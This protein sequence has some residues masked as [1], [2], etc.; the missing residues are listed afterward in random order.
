MS[1]VPNRYL[2]GCLVATAMIVATHAETA[3]AY[4]SVL[5][6]KRGA[7][8]GSFVGARPGETGNDP[9]RR[10]ERAIGRRF[11]VDHRY[12]R[13]DQEL[14][15]KN[16]RASFRAGRLP[17]VSWKAMRVDGG[18]VPWSEIADGS[19]DDWLVEQARR[20]KAF[21]A[22]MYLTFHHEPED[23]EENGSAGEF[24]AAFRHVVHIFREQ[25]VRNVAFI[26]T[27]MSWTFDVRSGRDPDDWYPGDRFVDIIGTDGYNWFPQKPGAPWESF[28]RVFSPTM[29]FANDRGKPVFV[30]EFGVMEDPEDPDRK[31]DWFR[32]AL[33]TARQ[34]PRLKGLIY[35]D[36][37][38]D[39]YPWITDSSTTALNGYSEIAA[40]RW[41][42]ELPPRDR[43]P[44]GQRSDRRESPVY[45]T[46]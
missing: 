23:D 34:W 18:L 37:V 10:V 17:L 39:G 14:P 35:F 36:V 40:S 22:P 5:E 38:K 6:P 13:W 16:E 7:Y 27:M 42:S 44:G 45:P 29:G 46:D 24:A 30:V 20:F 11:A 21:G 31:A 12:Y 4:P 3:L 26:W 25:R 41:L 15:T 8:L 28:R 2:V 32:R 19:H 9:I 33:A 1:V 43:T